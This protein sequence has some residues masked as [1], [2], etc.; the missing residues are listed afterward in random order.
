[1]GDRH[2]CA[3]SV[4]DPEGANLEVLCT[5]IHSRCC[6][7]DGS[8]QD[9]QVSHPFTFVSCPIFFVNDGALTSLLVKDA[10]VSA[11]YISKPPLSDFNE[12][13]T[14]EDKPHAFRI[15]KKDLEN[16]GY[17]EGCGACDKIRANIPS[18]ESH[19]EACRERIRQVL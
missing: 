19:T 17:T 11:I 5:K 4:S 16:Y 2:V 6:R 7:I 18:R 10:A 8:V 14:K 3:I 15:L 13:V 12:P 1:M 9:T